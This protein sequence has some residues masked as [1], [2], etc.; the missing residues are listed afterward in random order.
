MPSI[1]LDIVQ[2]EMNECP[3]YSESSR[4]DGQKDYNTV[5]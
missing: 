2:I 4:G 3:Q 1:V 5:I